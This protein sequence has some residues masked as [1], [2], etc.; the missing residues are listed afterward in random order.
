MDDT[1][2]LNIKSGQTITGVIAFLF[3]I[4]AIGFIAV[5]GLP[6]RLSF[7]FVL[8]CLALLLSIIKTDFALIVLIFSM[9][10]SPEL[11]VGQIT[12]RQVVI[13]AD[14]I[15][16][17]IVFFGWLAKMAIYKELGLLRTSAL[18][19]PILTYISICIISSLIGISRGQINLKE[20]VFYILKYFEYFLLFFMVTNNIKDTR[21]IKIFIYA[22][23]SVCFIIGLYAW[24]L[25]LLGVTR[26]TAPFEGEAGEANTLAG[27]LLLMMATIGGLIIHSSYKLRL[28]LLGLLVFIIP[29]FLFTLSRGAWFAFI[30]MYLSFLII[31]KRAKIALLFI[32]IIAVLILP[33][34]LPGFVKTRIKYTFVPGKT[35]NI[36]G[37]SITFDESTIRRV[38]SWSYA[39]KK[40]QK[41]PI[42][43]YG[44]P[45]GIVTDNQYGRVLRETGIVGFMAFVWLM[46]M[47]FRVAYY[48]Y[49]FSGDDF[50]RGIALG[51]LCGFIGLLVHGLSSEVFIIIRIMEPFWFLAAIVSRLPEVSVSGAKDTSILFKY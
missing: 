22:L 6:G 17:F 23:I 45:A 10:L 42:L 38:E 5:Y 44:V 40:W 25:H 30:P 51:F 43:G 3:S 32:L 14:D 36:Y 2:L 28:L 50:S 7:V 19:T 35:Y 29:P 4:L 37:K 12:G 46:M 26:V 8:A 1:K 34:S 16:L 9:L 33:W 13:R 11:R 39:F 31:S 21:Q 49:R 47:I 18:N 41:R 48:A 20:T 15:M 27:Y 24:Q